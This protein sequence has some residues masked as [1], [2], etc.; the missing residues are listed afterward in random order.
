MKAKK[1]LAAIALT[2]AATTLIAC[3]DNDR[4]IDF[5]TYWNAEWNVPKQI[6]ETLEYNVAFENTN[7][8]STVNYELNYKNGS[9]TTHLVAD[10]LYEYTY[11]TTL[12]IT[13]VYSYDGETEELQDRVT[14]KVTFNAENGLIPIK[15]EKTIVSHSPTN[16]RV[17]RVSQAYNAFYRHIETD[18]TGEKAVCKVWDTEPNKDGTPNEELLSEETF[19]GKSGKYSYTDNEMLLL[20]LRCVSTSVDSAKV[21]VYSPFNDE[22][23]KIKL[24]FTDDD[25]SMEASYFDHAVSDTVKKTIP[26]R[27]VTLK[28]SSSN[29]GATQ[30]AWIAKYDNPQASNVHRNVMLKLETPLAYNLGTLVYTLKSINRIEK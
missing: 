23:Q 8:Q 24:S 12:S 21:K 22:M 4:S 26:Y 19:N 25:E 2:L 15:S 14:T 7:S 9:Y 3:G 17:S 27:T 13:A 18:Y 1:L 30:K 11:T 20:S 16:S 6:D 29:P 10:T 28:L 5:S